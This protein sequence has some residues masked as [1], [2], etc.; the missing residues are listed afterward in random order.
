MPSKTSICILTYNRCSSVIALLGDMYPLINENTEIIV[1]DNHSTDDT[2]NRI[3]STF[4]RVRYFR[5]EK[6]IGASG[7]NLAFKNAR[8]EI[9]VC[10]DDDVFGFTDKSLCSLTKKFAANTIVGAINFKVVDAF[11]GELCNWVH[12]CLPSKNSDREFETYEITEGAVA[13][14]KEA[15]DKSGYY[16]DVY[17][18]SHE[19]PDLA[20]RMLRAGYQCIY[21]GD[22]IVNHRHENTGRVSWLNYYYDT[23]NHIYLAVKNFPV[24]YAIK[25]L[26]IGLLSMFIYSVRDGYCKYWL[27]AV[28]D[29]IMNL[30]K[31]RKTRNVLPN[32][33]MSIIR[34][35]NKNKTPIYYKLKSRI[36]RKS[37]RL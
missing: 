2:S 35:I 19:G 9:I 32:N 15:L 7:R 25:Y 34:D 13:F 8:G 29:G 17:F 11:T 4:P 27:K 37:A 16:D 21:W 3:L 12:R 5:T 36:F 26:T 23:R 28:A 10:L 33:V 31:I 20:F 1:V 30:N 24:S 18:I 22:I 6:N 14:R